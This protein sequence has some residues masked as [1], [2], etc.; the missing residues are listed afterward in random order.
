MVADDDPGPPSINLAGRRSVYEPFLR[1]I[2]KFKI[3]LDAPVIQS[4]SIY[5]EMDALLT[6][7]YISSR[8]VVNMC[9][10]GL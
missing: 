8:L 2:F 1:I 9:C 4:T 7:E 6:S 10:G 5:C 3:F